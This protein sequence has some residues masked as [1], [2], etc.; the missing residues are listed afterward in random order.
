MAIKK[1]NTGTKISWGQKSWHI[2]KADVGTHDSFTCSFDYVWIGRLETEY[3][4]WWTTIMSYTSCWRAVR[5]KYQRILIKA[6]RWW[7]SKNTYSNGEIKFLMPLQYLWGLYH[8]RYIELEVVLL[9]HLWNPRWKNRH[10]E[11]KKSDGKCFR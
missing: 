11:W 4:Y 7:W 9:C 1:K 8:Q 10:T 6:W 3:S 5:I 2:W